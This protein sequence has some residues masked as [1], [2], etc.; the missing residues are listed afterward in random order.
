LAIDTL[1]SHSGSS[2]GDKEAKVA[3]GKGALR[4]AYNGTWLVASNGILRWRGGR[5]G[6]WSLWSDKGWR[7]DWLGHDWLLV[8]NRLLILNW[9][10]NWSLGFDGSLWGFSLDRSGW[11]LGWRLDWRRQL[12]DRSVSVSVSRGEDW[13]RWSCGR[14]SWS[15][16]LWNDRSSSGATAVSFWDIVA[17]SDDIS[18]WVGEVDVL[19]WWS[20]ASVTNVGLENLRTLAES[21]DVGVGATNGDWRATHVHLSVADLVEPGPGENG[22]SRWSVLRNGVWKSV[23]ALN[24]IALGSDRASTLEGLDDREARSGIW[25]HI[26]S[27]R[28]LARSTTMRSTTSSRQD[29]LARLSWLNGQLALEIVVWCHAWVVGSA[30]VKW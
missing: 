25:L 29:N 5:S 12:D 9:G 14:R 1:G 16:W 13:G 15:R 20:G 19:A 8:L 17:L 24:L 2:H 11:L 22:L 27:Q 7:T 30:G 26:V 3:E 6:N 18:T 4:S 10:L 21:G 28:D 23:W